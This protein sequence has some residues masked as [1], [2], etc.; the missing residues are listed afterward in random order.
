MSQK[1]V[2]PLEHFLA[3]ALREVGEVSQ[4]VDREQVAQIASVIRNAEAGGARVHVTGVGKPEHLAHY[5]ASLFASTGTP[6]TF[7][8]ATETLHGSLGQLTPGDIVI[9]ISNSGETVELIDAAK[10]LTAFGARVIAVTGER[11]STLASASEFVLEARVNEEG[12]PLGLAPR[13]S[14]LAALLVLMALS[15]ELQA[16]KGF[17]REDYHQRHPAGSLGR[18]SKT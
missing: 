6:A 4:S 15:V 11:Q 1:I 5:V 8:H 14:I 9:A 12:G 13:A 18:R 7:L 3:T 10:A 16:S 17:S 2:N